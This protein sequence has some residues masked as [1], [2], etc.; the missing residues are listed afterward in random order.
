MSPQ[1]RVTSI[2]YL[3]EVAKAWATSSFASARDDTFAL[4]PHRFELDGA[5]VRRR[6]L[7]RRSREASDPLAVAD[8]MRTPAVWAR[9]ETATL[10]AD[11]PSGSVA[12]EQEIVE[13]LAVEDDDVL[14]EAAAV[15]RIPD[16]PPCLG[17]FWT[18][19]DD[20]RPART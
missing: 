11:S 14:A 12:Y 18:V 10:L 4:A 3:A 5:T 16:L 9:S 15:V 2:E 1:P 20:P 6:R 13:I 17:R 19:P 7:R 8:R